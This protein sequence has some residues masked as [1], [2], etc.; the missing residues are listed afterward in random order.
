MLKE[1]IKKEG[2]LQCI[3]KID[4]ILVVGCG[5]SQFSYGLY[6]DG[7]RNITNIDYSEIVIK[8]M[9]EKYKVYNM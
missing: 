3:Y 5:N 7:F 4:K 9:S 1:Y 6:S 2:I 8:N